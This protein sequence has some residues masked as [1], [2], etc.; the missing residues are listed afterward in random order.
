M[1]AEMGPRHARQAKDAD[2][3]FAYFDSLPPAT[4][5]K[6]LGRWRGSSFETG[7]PLDGLLESYGWY[8]KEFID[9][10]RVH[11]L[12]FRR[13]P[14]ALTNV[15]PAPLPMGLLTR[16]PTFM[17]GTIASGAFR[18]VQPLLRTREPKARL[19]IVEHRSVQTMAMIYDD[20]PIVDVFRQ[21]D[22][23]TLLGVMDLRGMREPF[24]FMLDRDR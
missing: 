2:A 10:E 1:L 12:V 17:R 19:R 5:E 8:G 15:N 18:A 7:H 13:S 23:D 3:A 4:I 22:E 6:C 14:R 16:F 21:V 24:F 20:Q 9:A 11:P